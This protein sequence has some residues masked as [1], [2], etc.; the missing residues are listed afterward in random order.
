MAPIF[1]LIVTGEKTATEFGIW[2][3]SV[4]A[5]HPDA[6]AYVFTD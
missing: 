6:E 5:W 1:A 3:R 2:A 4:Q